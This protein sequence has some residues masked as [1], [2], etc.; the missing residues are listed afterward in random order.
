M[1]T[2]QKSTRDRR[3]TKAQAA[4]ARRE[5]AAWA[6]EAAAAPA[7]Q[8]FALIERLMRL[9]DKLEVVAE[10]FEAA[11]KNAN[12]PAEFTGEIFITIDVSEELSGL[13]GELDDWARRNGAPQIGRLDAESDPASAAATPQQSPEVRSLVD[14]LA[15]AIGEN[16]QAHELFDSLLDALWGRQPG[17]V[18]P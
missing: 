4:K 8:P 14:R 16:A 11:E 1:A 13:A 15:E 17:E 9:R 7:P 10:A 3:P 12:L 2:K 18:R 6:P 5:L